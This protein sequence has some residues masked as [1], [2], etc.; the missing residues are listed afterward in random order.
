MAIVTTVTASTFA[1]AFVDMGRGDQ[2]SRDALDALF[3]Y[4][5]QV[6]E[7]TGSNIELD[8]IGICCDWSEL[9]DDQLY[10]EYGTTEGLAEHDG[11]MD[12]YKESI[13]EKLEDSTYV[14]QLDNG[15]VLIQAFWV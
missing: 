2:F 7:G 13:L 6:S 15:N 9:E 12:E 3:E 11:D 5:E 14:I 10:I 1:N 8:V 4:Y